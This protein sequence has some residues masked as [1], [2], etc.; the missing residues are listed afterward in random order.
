MGEQ[1]REKG[2]EMVSD[3]GDS[4]AKVATNCFVFVLF[5][6]L[7]VACRQAMGWTN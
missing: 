2:V 7:V 6:G 4:G 5:A 3:P 1:R